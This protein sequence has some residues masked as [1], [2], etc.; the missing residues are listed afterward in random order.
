MVVILKK[1]VVT[2]FLFIEGKGIDCTFFIFSILKS[3]SIISLS[4][5]SF[6]PNACILKGNK[7][8]LDGAIFNVR[9]NKSY[10]VSLDGIFFA[11]ILNANASEYT[12]T[13]LTTETHFRRIFRYTEDEADCEGN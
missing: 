13:L 8:C 10:I 6:G 11:D 7:F 12:V 9:F 2:Y 4:S 5:M 3:R 1:K